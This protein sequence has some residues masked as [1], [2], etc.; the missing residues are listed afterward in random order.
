M[1]FCRSR[2][3]SRCWMRCSS[4]G[5]LRKRRR[6]TDSRRSRSG[7][8]IRRGSRMT[9]SRRG[10]SVWRCWTPASSRRRRSSAHSRIASM[11]SPRMW[12]DGRRTR[13]LPARSAQRRRLTTRPRRRTTPS[14]RTPWTALSPRSRS[15]PPNGRRQSLCRPSC[16][17]TACASCPWLRRKR[18]SPSYSSPT[19]RRC[20]MRISSTSRRRHMRTSSSPAA[21]WTCSR[22]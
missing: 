18:S 1:A 12:A 2:R 8:L 13:H 6:R 15:S 14:H 17:C 3:S 5:E 22:S 7:A 21:S 16:R 4:R 20:R 10:L 19:W 9:K 11:S